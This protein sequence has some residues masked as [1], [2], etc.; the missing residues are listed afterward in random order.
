MWPAQGAPG[1]TFG[2]APVQIG[3]GPL[4]G[5][6]AVPKNARRKKRTAER[7]PRGLPAGR[8]AGRSSGEAIDKML[9]GPRKLDATKSKMEH[10]ARTGGAPDD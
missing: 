5:E 6:R 7:E 2:S 8:I 3:F 1:L 4:I 9:A 10:V